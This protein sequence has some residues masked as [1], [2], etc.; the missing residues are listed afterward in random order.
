MNPKS[1]GEKTEA[2]VLAE[3]VKNDYTVLLPFGDNKRY[4][5]VIST[6]AGF[7]RLQCKTGRLRD[8]SVWFRTS[9]TTSNTRGHRCRDYKGEIDYFVVY[10][11][12]TKQTY[13]VPVDEAGIKQ[14][15]LRVSPLP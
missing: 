2:I 10:C 7:K 4:D 14:C 6:A 13:M 9:S 11:Y 3:L 8:G 12:E 5:F 15:A 1:I